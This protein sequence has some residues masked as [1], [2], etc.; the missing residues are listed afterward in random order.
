[1]K[2]TAQ[3]IS[4]RFDDDGTNFFESCSPCAHI[5]DVCESLCVRVDREIDKAEV[6]ATRYTFADDSAITISGGAWDLVYPD[7]FCWHAAGHRDD[8]EH[9]G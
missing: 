4:A 6:S 5:V 1:M 7:C 3:K 8:C 9:D 2:T